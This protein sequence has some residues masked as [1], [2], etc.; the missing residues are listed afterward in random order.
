V[1]PRIRF[2]PTD[3]IVIAGVSFQIFEQS[4][5]GVILQQIDSSNINCSYAHSEIPA[6][7]AAP[8]TKLKRGYFSESKA[9]SRLS[10]KKTSSLRCS[11]QRKARTRFGKFLL[12]KSLWQRWRPGR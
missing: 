10:K 4:K 8:D 12:S 3:M 6:L 11:L 1:S 5:R 9:D 7:L 2:D